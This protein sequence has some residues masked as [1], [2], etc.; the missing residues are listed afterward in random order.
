VAPHSD[1]TIAELRAW[2]LADHG[3]SVSHG[4]AWS[5]SDRLNLTPKKQLRAAHQDRPDA[6]EAR[7]ISR[8]QRPV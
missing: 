8:E 2:L 1:P 3:V 5:A 7:A 4:S 6:A